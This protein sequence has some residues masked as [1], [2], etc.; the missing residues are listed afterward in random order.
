MM[1]TASWVKSEAV[2]IMYIKI[3]M[4]SA[5]YPVIKLLCLKNAFGV[6]SLD[7]LEVPCLPNAY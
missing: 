3:E 6:E 5:D 4:S 2:E 1:L 7:T